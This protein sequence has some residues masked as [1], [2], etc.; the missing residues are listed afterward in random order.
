MITIL[1]STTSCYSFSGFVYNRL[2]FS[3]SSRNWIWEAL[4]CST[5]TATSTRRNCCGH[6]WKWLVSARGKQIA[7]DKSLECRAYGDEWTLVVTLSVTWESF[8][9]LFVLFCFF[10]LLSTVFI[11]EDLPQICPHP[12][13][14]LHFPFCPKVKVR[15][16]AV[17][18]ESLQLCSSTG[19]QLPQKLISGSLTGHFWPENP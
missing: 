14:L 4:L 12:S 15:R 2:F 16:S 19:P 11:Q 13:S 9:P 5:G 3:C 6:K 10:L 7:E 8:W 1:Q 18:S 17:K